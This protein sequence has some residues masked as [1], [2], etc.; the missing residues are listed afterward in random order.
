MR[1]HY[2]PISSKGGAFLWD[3][4][5]EKSIISWILGN[6]H[7]WLIFLVSLRA[8]SWSLAFLEIS[9]VE[10]QPCLNFWK[11]LNENIP[12]TSRNWALPPEREAIGKVPHLLY[13]TLSFFYYD[14]CHTKQWGRQRSLTWSGFFTSLKVIETDFMS[15]LIS[16]QRDHNWS[17]HQCSNH[18]WYVYLF[19]VI[20][21]TLDY[22]YR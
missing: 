17:R 19:L 7:Y 14:F 9:F 5:Y 6:F 21:T 1:Y 15:H 13:D 2:Y 11:K 3:T 12:S 20:D 16:L 18:P 8:A 10:R 4:R 22:Q